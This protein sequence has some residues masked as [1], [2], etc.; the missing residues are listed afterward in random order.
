M[1]EKPNISDER[2][3]SA[4]HE[5]FSLRVR[6]IEFIP[7]GWDAASSSYRVEA[8]GDVYFLKIRT[9]IPNPAGILIPRF[10]KEQGIEQVMAPLSSVGGEA[11]EEVDGLCFILY[12]FVAG[13]QVLEVGMGDEHWIEFGTALKRLH[14][15]KL[16]P[17]ILNQ[18]QRERFVPPRLAWIQQIHARIQTYEP[19]DPFQKDLTEFW[20]ENHARISLILERTDTLIKRMEESD[21]NFVPCHGDVHTGNLLITED[22][23][24]FIVDWEDARLAPK[25]RDLIFLPGDLGKK[26]EE[27]FFEGYGNPD[28]DPLLQAYYRH[29]WCVEDMGF[30][31]HIFTTEEVG[32]QTKTDAIFWFKSLFPPGKSIDLALESKID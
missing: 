15:T 10:L 9:S 19:R 11:W 12:P 21:V 30:A 2:I 27:L 16:S 24:L 17:E 31:E 6:A 7:L 4:L 3:I 20:L 28:I 29:H 1:I 25:E 5:H 13:K 18:I 14:S 26:Q 32:E 8:E 22:G 23:K